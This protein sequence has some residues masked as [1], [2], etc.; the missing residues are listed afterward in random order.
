MRILVTGTAGLI[1]PAV[2]A[3]LAQESYTIIGAERGT[4]AVMKTVLQALKKAG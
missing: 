2:C 4:Q 3:R 1:G